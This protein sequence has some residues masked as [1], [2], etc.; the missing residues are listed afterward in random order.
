MNVMRQSFVTCF[1]PQNSFVTRLIDNFHGFQ[2]G[3]TGEQCCRF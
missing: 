3:E 1:M 2:S